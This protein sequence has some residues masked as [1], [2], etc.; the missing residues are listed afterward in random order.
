MLLTMAVYDTEENDRSWMTEKTLVSLSD[1]VD[2]ERHRLIISDNGSCPE[3]KELYGACYRMIEKVIYNGKNIGTA[4]ALNKAWTHRKPN[5]VVCKVDNDV[6]WHRPGW[7]DLI[8]MV[9]AKTTNIG[10][11][12]LKRRD[13]DES[14]LNPHKF[15]QTS[16]QA[17]PHDKTKN[18]PFLVVEVANHVIGTCQAYSPKLLDKIGYLWQPGLYGFDDALA[19]ARARVAGFLCVFLYECVPIDHIDP[20]GTEFITWKQQHAGQFMNEY[21]KALLQYAHGER[22]VYYDGGFDE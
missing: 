6:V 7:A 3:T 11:C 22:D 18:E 17:I 13:L 5:E 21:R 15:Y 10:I 12:G 20:G 2:F 1:T 4:A 16:L 14:P 8:E 9:F 19:C